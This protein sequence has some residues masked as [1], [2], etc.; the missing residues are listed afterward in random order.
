M[1]QNSTVQIS[2]DVTCATPVVDVEMEATNIFKSNMIIVDDSKLKDRNLA[3]GGKQKNTEKISK[4]KLDGNIFSRALKR[5]Q[6][7]GKNKNKKTDVKNIQQYF[8][9]PSKNK[10]TSHQHQNST[11]GETKK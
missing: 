2:T 3:S 11:K 7:F 5:A 1:P 4:E 8:T 10:E 6:S 9:L